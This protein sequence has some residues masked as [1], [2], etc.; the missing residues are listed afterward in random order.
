[1]LVLFH[2][3]TTSSYYNH[4]DMNLIKSFIFS[5]LLLPAH[6]LYAQAQTDSVTISGRV[7]DYSGQAIGNCSVMFQNSNFDPLFETKT[8]KDGNYQI[9]IPKGRYSNLGAIDMDTYPHTMK[10]GSDQQELRLEFWGWNVVADR[11]TTLNIRYHRM[12][13]YGLHV[14]Q[15]PG[16]MPT[17]QIYV[18]PMS[19]TRFLANKG[20]GNAQH[21]EDLSDITQTVSADS[22]RCDRL[23]PTIDKA[24]IKVWVDGEE[25]PVLMKQQI[26]EYYKATEYG[27]AYYLTVDMPKRKTTLPYH[28]F[29]VELTDLENGDRGEAVYYLEKTDYIEN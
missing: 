29:R 15:I 3:E 26:K 9:R 12:E 23:A 20:I 2:F 7:T 24:D 27:I 18:R 1:M 4:K 13:A 21:K 22:A 25:V 19:L 17:Y 16:G 14:F 8:D 11:D 6:V 28:V 10:S 5:A